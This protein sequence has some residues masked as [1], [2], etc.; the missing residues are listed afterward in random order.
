MA[1]FIAT[2][3]LG[4]MTNVTIAGNTAT[5]VG[6]GIYSSGRTVNLSLLDTTVAANSAA[7]TGGGI[8]SASGSLSIANTIIAGNSVTAMSGT[9]PDVSGAFVSNGYN[10]IGKADTG[11]GFNT[12][13]STG[14]I[15]SPINA[16][17]GALADNGG[18]TQT[19]LPQ[20]GSPAIDAGSNALI[21]SGLTIDQ[22]GLARISNGTVDIGAVEVQAVAP[23]ISS[24]TVDSGTAQRSRVR[25]LDASIH[26]PRHP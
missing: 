13:D 3:G 12:H 22:R 26:N 5:S 21:P 17:L 15:A 7:M 1:A 23:D 10:L 4:I 19:M 16:Q 6:G 20:A 14:S 9:G 8:D 2:G 24:F 25:T 18:F 11:S